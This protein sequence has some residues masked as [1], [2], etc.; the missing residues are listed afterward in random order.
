MDANNKYTFTIPTDN[1]TIDLPLEI[2]WDFYG[3]DDS[4][5]VYETDVI[6]EVIGSPDDFEILR[7]AHDSYQNDT[8]TAVNYDFYFYNGNVNNVDTSTLSNWE[9]SYLPEGFLSTEVY[10]YEKPFTKSFFKL[11]FYDTNDSTTHTNYF[12]I[13]IPVQQGKTENVS[14]SSTI[15]HT[16]SSIKSCMVTSPT[17]ALV[18]FSSTFKLCQV[19]MVCVRPCSFLSPK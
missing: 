18:F 13:I 19:Q 2:K 16:T 7:F 8:K 12:T 1:K 17:P 10:Y 14:T 3:R 11:D 5:D 4:I 9:I 15:T 6:K